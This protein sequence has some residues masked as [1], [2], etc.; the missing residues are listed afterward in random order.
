M[1]GE[2]RKV[3]KPTQNQKPIG[4]ISAEVHDVEAARRKR[5]VSSR[6]E[7]VWEQ[8]YSCSTCIFPSSEAGF[9][10]N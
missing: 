9:Q 7:K 4:S 5:Q 6:N 2:Q 8:N 3:S 10:M 1:S